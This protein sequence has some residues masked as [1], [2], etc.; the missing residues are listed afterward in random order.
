VLFQKILFLL[1]CIKSHAQGGFK[2]PKLACLC[3]F[4]SLLSAPNR[5]KVFINNCNRDTTI[6]YTGCLKNRKFRIQSVVGKD[7]VELFLKKI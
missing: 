3:I 2:C 5:A 6:R 7:P 4:L 1:T